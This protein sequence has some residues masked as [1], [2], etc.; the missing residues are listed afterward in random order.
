MNPKPSGLKK[1]DEV[2]EVIYRILKSQG[3]TEPTIGLRSR[4]ISIARAGLKSR[5]SGSTIHK[6]NY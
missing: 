5:D 1:L 4:A 2:Q 3:V 6:R